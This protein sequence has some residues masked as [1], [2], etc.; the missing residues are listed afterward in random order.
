MIK[1][2]DQN[3]Y[4]FGFVV[5]L[6]GVFLFIKQV[7]IIS[8]LADNLW[9]LFIKFWPLLLLFLGIE[10][11]ISNNRI[12]GGIILLLSVSFLFN[13]LLDFNFFSVLWPILIIGIG[14]S[15]LFKEERKEEKKVKDDT[16][17][18][19]QTLLFK[20][21]NLKV[22]S[23]NFKGGRLDMFVGSLKLDLREAKV[24]KGGAKLNIN[25]VFANVKVLVPKECRVKSKG[26]SVIGD[27][28]INLNE[29]ER[30]EPVLNINGNILFG[31]VK[32][33]E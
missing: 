10:L 29:R 3:R 31:E 2:K 18:L 13:T 6:I 30:E 4:L 25:A 5:V 16:S 9:T 7:G 12:T 33:E 19:S 14:V 20:D 32:I 8:P 17:Y 1:E 15:L 23:Q 28:T 11:Y 27:W 22:D 24:S 26:S 21:E